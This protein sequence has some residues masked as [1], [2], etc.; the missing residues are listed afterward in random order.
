MKKVESLRELNRIVQKPNYKK[1]GNWMARNITRDMALPLTWIVLYLPASANSVTFIS[2][3]VGLLGC[4]F[5]SFG[6]EIHFLWGAIL[7]QSWYLLDHV[8]GQIARYRKQESVTGIFFDYITHHI[9]HMGIFIGVGWGVYSHT[10][11][12][13]YILFGTISAMSILFLNLIYD[14]QYKAFF[15]RLGEKKLSKTDGN[16]KYHATSNNFKSKRAFWSRP[17]IIFT[18]VHKI[19]EVHVLM[20][21]LTGLAIIQ[22]FLK[23][24]LWSIFIS[25][26]LICTFIVF[27]LKMTYFIFKHVPDITFQEFVKSIF[28]DEK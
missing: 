13:K 20:N 26:Y 14:C 5:L 1:V 28:I 9:I 12:V 21:I 24:Y 23:G 4:I 3:I 7:L 15:H 2:L 27:A 6:A 17:K 10:S 8:D 16:K 11:E 19:C 18:W 22:Y 25:F